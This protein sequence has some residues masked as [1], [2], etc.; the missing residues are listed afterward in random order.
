MSELFSLRFQREQLYTWKVA[1]Q[2]PWDV[3]CGL[4]TLLHVLDLCRLFDECFGVI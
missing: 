1:L 2:E 3:K 4:I